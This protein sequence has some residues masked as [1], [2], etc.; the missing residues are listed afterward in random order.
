METLANH[1]IY[2]VLGLEIKRQLN[3]WFIC[4]LKM[5]SVKS[6]SKLNVL[7]IL[8][9]IIFLKNEQHKLRAADFVSWLLGKL[10]VCIF[11]A[12]SGSVH[13]SYRLS[14]SCVADL[15]LQMLKTE[16]CSPFSYPFF[17]LKWT[18]QHFILI[19]NCEIL[20]YHFVLVK[21]VITEQLCWLVCG[22]MWKLG[23]WVWPIYP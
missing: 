18:L 19:Q 8:P 13:K 1:T 14:V 20:C 9:F 6:F 3:L 15:C 7:G 22:L 5:G 10:L 17:F 23:S 2:G 12:L 21:K 16:S 11:V 4:W